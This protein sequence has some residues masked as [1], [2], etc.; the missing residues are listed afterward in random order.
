LAECCNAACRR[1]YGSGGQEASHA[2]V[3][4]WTGDA[5]QHPKTAIYYAS[6]FAALLP[7]DPA[8]WLLFALPPTI[9][10]IETGWYAIVAL[11]FSS[12]SPRAAYLRSKTWVDRI[13]GAILGAL[14]A[15]LLL[16]GLPARST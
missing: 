4:A 14:G 6:I 13:A 9:F 2:L 8:T 10:V 12:S 15:R 7:A 5:G 1:G 11:A 3:L 16:D